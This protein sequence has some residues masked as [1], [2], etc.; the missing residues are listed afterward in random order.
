MRDPRRALIGLRLPFLTGSLLP[1]WAAWALASQ[2]QAV[3]VLDGL[4]VTLAVACLHLGS[5][6]LNDYFDTDHSDRV[7]R[8]R[9]PFSGGSRVILDGVLSRRGALLLVAVLYGAAGLIGILFAVQRRPLV[10]AFG[11]AG[12]ALG[13]V[14]SVTL[15]NRGLG[16][17]AIFLAFGPV[18]TLGTGYALSGHV[19]PTQ[20]LLGTLPGYLIT[21]VLWINQFPD[22]AADASVG[23]RHLVVRLGKRHARWG[24]LALMLLPFPTLAALVVAGILPPLALL[25]ALALPIVLK[26]LAT[27]WHRWD[28]PQGIQP[29][30]ALTIQSHLALTALLAAALAL[31]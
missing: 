7:N 28:D 12:F 21:A 8:W 20:A 24:Y 19:D 16:E 2:R 18:L 3:R 27:F 10:L 9:T 15:M 6:L 22:F 25:T 5:N 31:A 1:V 29:A 23:K 4:A 11:L 13:A 17:L 26:A 14:Y 30:Q